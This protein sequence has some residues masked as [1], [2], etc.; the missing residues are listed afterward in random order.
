MAETLT[1]VVAM[2]RVATDAAAPESR[3]GPRDTSKGG[4]GAGR[5]ETGLL[6]RRQTTRVRLWRWL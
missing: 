6:R 5:A 2:T 3:P 4:P 1:A